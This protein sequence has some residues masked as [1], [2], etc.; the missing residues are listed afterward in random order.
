[1]EPASANRGF[2]QVQ[3]TLKNQFLHDPSIKRVFRLFLPADIARTV[4]PEISHLGDEVLQQQIFDWVTD[5]EKN[6]PYIAGRGRNAFGQPMSTRLVVTEGWRKLQ[7]FS[8]EKGF[9]SQGHEAGLDQYTRIVQYLRELI[10]ESSSAN[11]GCPAA[12]ADGAARVLQHH[13]SNSKLSAEEKKV[14]QNAYDH[15][16]SRD[17]NMAWTS[18]QW[19]TERIGGSDVSRSETIATYSPL[20]NDGPLCDP[21]ENIPIGPWIIDGFKWF[22]S[23]TDSNMT[24]LLA[25]TPKGL[26]AFYAPMR[27]YNPSLVSATGAVGGTELNGVT[28]SRLKNKMGTKSLP[29]AE[30]ELRGMR[31]WLL[32]KE[33][34]GIKE[35]SKILTITRIRS[36]ISALGYLSR[37]MAVARAFAEV[38]EVGAGRG[39]RMKLVDSAL[40]MRSLSDMTID[41]H[42]MMLLTFYSSYLLGLEEHST[43][44]R[45]PPPSTKAITPPSEYVTPLLRVITP[46]LKAYVTKQAIPLIYACMESLGGVGYLENSESEYMNIARLFRDACVLNIWEGTT[47]VLATDFIRALKHPKAGADGIRALDWVIKSGESGASIVKQWESLKAELESSTQEDLLPNAR[48]ILWKLAEILMA[49]LF[50][51]DVK[52]SDGP[53]IQEMCQRYLTSRGFVRDENSS[54]DRS[55]TSLELNRA[56]VFGVEHTTEVPK[57]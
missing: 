7:A 10:F 57:L 12:M 42:A 48:G 47:D 38:R 21:E 22:S 19:M 36:A 28:I 6:H 26:S 16:I 9:V 14:F 56:I 49:V 45:A 54:S 1:M 27:R 53:V 32:G 3:P 25:Q 41:Q 5:A 8:V 2:F 35:I 50:M 33:G 13:L 46:L 44:D 24:I 4:L 55:Q 11:V 51:L 15:L 37:G 43:S 30:L 39:K 29:T 17:P 20:P 52:S 34:E 40:H 31:G 18:G 23:A